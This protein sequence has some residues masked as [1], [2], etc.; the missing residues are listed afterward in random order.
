MSAAQSGV[1]DI[2]VDANDLR[3]HLVS[4]GQ[5]GYPIVFMLHHLSGTAHTLDPIAEKLA[6]EYHVYCLDTRGR[7]ES[8]WGKADDYHVG[9]YI[10]DLE[11]IRRA[12]GIERFSLIGSSD[13]GTTALHYTA[14]HQAH[15]D[16]VVLNDMGPELD[17]AREERIRKLFA[18]AP[19][20][21]PDL[22]SVAQYYQENYAR[23]M[24]GRSSGQ[25]EEFAAHHVRRN[26]AGVWVWKM[27]PAV[28]LRTQVPPAMDAWE[29]YK[30]ITCPIQIIRGGD[31]HV[32]SGGV[33]E[34]MQREQP[35]A[36][37]VEVPGVGHPPIMTEPEAYDALRDFL[38][39]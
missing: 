27:D 13:G 29:D 19:K 34:R 36:D 17:S 15:V 14:R 23:M 30:K 26:D 16:K 7:G 28:R 10:E 9:T 4:R 18:K 25:V 3:H 39:T 11:E 33:A 6:D 38:A 1:R 5:P 2:F 21:F 12:L 22:K 20:M 8:G 31:S 24:S 35:K 37:Y 32:L